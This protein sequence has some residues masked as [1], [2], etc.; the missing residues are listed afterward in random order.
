MNRTSLLP[1]IRSCLNKQQISTPTL[2]AF[3]SWVIIVNSSKLEY[4]YTCTDSASS[5]MGQRAECGSFEGFYFF[6][7]YPKARFAIL[8]AMLW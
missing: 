2:G 8:I 7:L 1:V 4:I 3:A 5:A 6:P